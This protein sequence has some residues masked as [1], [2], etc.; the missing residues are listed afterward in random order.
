MVIGSIIHVGHELIVILVV[1]VGKEVV[2]GIICIFSVV[3]VVVIGSV[4]GVG[5][6]G[7]VVERE[8]GGLWVRG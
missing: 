4:V 3:G 6:R 5:G 1:G 2:E 7:G 8:G